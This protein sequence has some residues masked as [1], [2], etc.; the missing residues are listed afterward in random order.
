LPEFAESRI[1]VTPTTSEDALP[2]VHDAMAEFS[3]KYG[4][5]SSTRWHSPPEMAWTDYG[6]GGGLFR[7]KSDSPNAAD[8]PDSLSV[9][10]GFNRTIVITYQ[11]K[12]DVRANDNPV[13]NDLKA[14]LHR[15]AQGQRIAYVYT[16]SHWRITGPGD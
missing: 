11:S 8:R 13:V 1:I 12:G 14:I 4:Y 5:Q 7:H 6:V 3:R 9:F 2:G 15:H 10:R 16:P